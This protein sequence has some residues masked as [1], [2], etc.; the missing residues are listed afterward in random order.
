MNAYSVIIPSKTLHNLTASVNAIRAAGEDC[1]IF[2]VDDGIQGEFWLDSNIDLI[3]GIKPFCF[4][5]NINLGIRA[6]G[7][8]DV[9]LLNDDA[10]LKTNLGFQKLAMAAYS[11]PELGIVSAVTN[12]VGNIAQLFRG[13]GLRFESRM[14]CFICVYIRRE[15]LDKCGLLDERFTGYGFEDDD[16]CLR[17]RNAGYKIGVNDHC[18]VDHATLMST[19]RNRGAAS[20]ALMAENQ[21]HFFTKWG[22]DNYGRKVNRANET[23][24]RR[25]RQAS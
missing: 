25:G 16:Y 12:S 7:K 1:K 15:A 19:F 2:I 24:S 17:L 10:L 6:A 11:S 8:N 22:H 5:R 23:Q 18:F 13:R 9:I 3:H 4:A 20:A 14:V 21:N